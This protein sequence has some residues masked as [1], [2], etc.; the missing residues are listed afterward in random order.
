MATF[1][2]ALIAAALSFGSV[3]VSAAQTADEVVEKHLTAL[4]GRAAL[5]K[6][7]SRTITGTI[8][9]T[10][11]AGDLSGPV[12]VTYAL[13]NK[14]RTLLTLDLSAFGAG[15]MTYDERF[16][17]S[18]GY[19]IDTLQ[20]NRDI[21][22]NQLHNL[23]NE[24]FP[25]PLLDYK[26]QGATLAL[27]G[28]EKFNDREAH[29]LVLTPKTGPASKRYID[30]ESFLETRTVTTTDNPT[31]G[32]FELTLDYSDFREVDGVKVAYQMRATSSAQNF[33]VMLT[34]VTNNQ[35]VDAALFSKPVQ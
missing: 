29:V 26:R 34:T 8:V 5:E 4:G 23:R 30:A 3:T 6:L 28:K 32:V 2:R 19:L 35:P 14:A 7:T 20:G 1:S 9:L 33:R 24:T 12:E 16:D 17:G 31:L 27:A 21:T 22:G 25:T 18:A 15:K 10:I 13:P 11:D